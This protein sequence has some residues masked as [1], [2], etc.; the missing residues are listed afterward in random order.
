MGLCKDGY[1]RESEF[2]DGKKYTASGKTQKAAIKSLSRKIADAKNGVGTINKNMTVG[3]WVEVWLETFVKSSDLTPKSYKNVECKVNRHIVGTIGTMKLRDVK[4]VHLQK[5]LNDQSGMSMSHVT[6]LRD[7]MKQIFHRALKS[8]LIPYSPA[9]DLELPKA[10]DKKRRPLT[11]EERSAI[12][13]TAQTHP[14]GLWVKTMLY[15]GLRPGETVPLRWCDIDFEK[16][17]V[18]VHQALESGSKD[19]IKSPKSKAGYRLVPIPEHLIADLKSQQGRPLEYIFTQT[20]PENKGKH[21]TPSSLRCYWD[22]F[23]RQ[24]DLDMG[25]EVYRNQIVKS[26]L[27]DDL[28][29]YVLR[30]TY[31]TDLQAAGVPINIAKYLMGHADIS[32]TANIYTHENE[33]TIKRAAEL[34]NF[35]AV[36]KTVKTEIKQSRDA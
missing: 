32:T 10:A 18:N 25:A 28:T 2:Y 14:A 22:S 9:D 8:K 1:Y 35:Y 13:K 30:H 20:L 17:V 31:G 6:K 15:C 26:K 11:D 36:K 16:N 23:K 4:E 33:E 3:A 29:P 7:Y 21:H 24:L 12:L 34:I 19:T 27:S 5:I